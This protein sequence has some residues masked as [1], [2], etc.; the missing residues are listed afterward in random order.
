M[1]TYM[2]IYRET[3]REDGK[4]DF[5]FCLFEDSF[6]FSIVRMPDR[7]SNVPSSIVYS[8]IG[9]ESLRIARGS[10]NRESFSTAIKPL[11]VRISR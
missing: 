11:I 1:H 5:D 10:N 8:A 2:Y 7:S 9:A 4:F 6:S 3:E